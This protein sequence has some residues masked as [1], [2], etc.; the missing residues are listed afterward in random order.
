MVAMVRLPQGLTNTAEKWSIAWTGV[1]R[2]GGFFARKRREHGSTFSFLCSWSSGHLV[3]QDDDVLQSVYL[4]T[5]R[6]ASSSSLA[7]GT[8]PRLELSCARAQASR[9]RM[10]EPETRRLLHMTGAAL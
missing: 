10:A 5:L 6:G 4:R 9:M 8:A 1:Y 3:G 2:K 7:K